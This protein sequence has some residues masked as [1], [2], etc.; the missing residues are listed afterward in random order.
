MFKIFNEDCKL[1][2]QRFVEENRKVNLILTSPP[3]NTQ[4]GKT[5]FNEKNFNQY[6]CRYDS[7]IPNMTVSDYISW[8]LDLFHWF[9]KILVKNGVVL[10]NLNYGSDLSTPE[11]RNL[12][13]LLVAS[14]VSNTSFSVADRIVWKKNSAFPNNMSKNKLTRIT[15]DI[16]VFVR[17]S[18]YATF[19]CNK[20]V[21]GKLNKNQN[22]YSV[23][24]NF[25]SAKNND[26]K[27]PFNK[28]TFSTEL[29][30]KLLEIYSIKNDDSFV[31]Y[32]PFGGTG[33][34]L[35]GARLRGI[36]GL[37]SEIS[38]NQCQYAQEQLDKFCSDEN[39]LF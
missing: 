2:M 39:S 17:D 25:I 24:Y 22:L 28:A 30:S 37:M 16:L 36:S 26:G 35:R 4:R 21:I 7:E 32:D 15:E 8:T 14:I 20:E 18:E 11:G 34:T 10:Y 3:Y 5:K 38:T 23:Y 29:V 1:T 27:N 19:F 33:T 6:L 9:D 31:V 13:W 12:L